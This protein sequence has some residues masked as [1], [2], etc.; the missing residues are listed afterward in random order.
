MRL[1]ALVSALLLSALA[2]NAQDL[3]RLG[4]LK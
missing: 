1:K 4:N 2:L 3:V